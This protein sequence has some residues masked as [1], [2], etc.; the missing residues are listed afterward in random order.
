MWATFDVNLIGPQ[1][2]KGANGEW[3]T[4]YLEPYYRKS[5]R[6]VRRHV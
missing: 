5:P 3:A 4:G 1:Q 2:K 6:I